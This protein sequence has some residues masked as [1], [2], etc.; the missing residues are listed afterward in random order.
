MAANTTKAYVRRT[1]I[2]D[3]W[4]KPSPREVK[5]NVD[6]CFHQDAF[7]GATGAII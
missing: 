7:A 2:R 4:T 5:L 1:T 3:K 6:A